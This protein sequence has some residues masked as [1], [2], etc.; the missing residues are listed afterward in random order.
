VLPGLT[1]LS[2]VLGRNDIPWKQRIQI[3]IEYIDGWSLTLDLRIIAHTLLMPL[4]ISL[5]EAR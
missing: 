3:D 1:G 4:G 5:F 2:V